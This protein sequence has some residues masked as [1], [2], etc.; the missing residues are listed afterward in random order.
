MIL[1][2]KILR[3]L[4]RTCEDVFYKKMYVLN[5]DKHEMYVKELNKKAI[6]PY[7]D[8]RWMSNDGIIT[9]PHGYDDL[10]FT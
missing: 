9:F 8:K 7:D 2:F 4:L 5:S 6:S 3:M 10:L 1:L